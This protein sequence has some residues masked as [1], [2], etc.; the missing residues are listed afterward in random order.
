MFPIV[1]VDSTQAVLAQKYTLHHGTLNAPPKWVQA[2]LEDI[3]PEEGWQKAGQKAPVTLWELWSQGLDLERLEA[4]NV[5]KAEM[6]DPRLAD[7]FQSL[8]LESETKDSE[9]DGD[10]EGVWEELFSA[11]G[12]DRVGLFIRSPHSMPAVAEQSR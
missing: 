9:G 12:W 2:V 6:E 5:K 4:L 1:S 10:T 8:G 11:G 3:N 7:M